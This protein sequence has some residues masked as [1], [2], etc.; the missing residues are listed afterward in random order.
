MKVKFQA[1][2]DLDGRIVRGLRRANREIDIL[3][4]AAAGLAGL[5]DPHVLR[6]ASESGRILVSQDRRPGHFHRFV[7]INQSA[8]VLIVREATPIATAIDDLALI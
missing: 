5:D 3:T 4:S 7:L 1:D 8:G 6:I 2:A